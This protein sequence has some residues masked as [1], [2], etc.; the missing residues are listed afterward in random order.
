MKPIHIWLIALSAP[1]LFGQA[2][3]RGKLNGA[4]TLDQLA[5]W[6]GVALPKGSYS[7]AIQYARAPVTATLRSADGKT[8]NFEPLIVLAGTE[9]GHARI[10]LVICESLAHRARTAYISRDVRYD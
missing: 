6:G 2:S 8:N 5:T 7:L 1:L 4:V 10:C 9:T 3:P